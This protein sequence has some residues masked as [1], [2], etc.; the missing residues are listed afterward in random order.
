LAATDRRKDEEMRSRVERRNWPA[1]LLAAVL[2]LFF[3]WGGTTG[4]RAAGTSNDAMAKVEEIIGKLKTERDSALRVDAA[5][6]L[7]RFLQRLS[8]TEVLD[9]QVVDDLAGLL[10]DPNDD[11]RFW[12]AAALGHFAARARGAVPALERAL[13]NTRAASSLSGIVPAL[14]SESAILGALQRITGRP[15]SSWE[16]N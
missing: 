11:V 4:L 8:N 1:L 15:A 13:K 6:E 10:D 12:V 5:E 14:T 9:V 7:S 3:Y 16:A 2:G